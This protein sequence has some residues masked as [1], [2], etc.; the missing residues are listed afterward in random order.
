M[1]DAHSVSRTILPT[2]PPQWNR[3]QNNP[4]GSGVLFAATAIAAIVGISLL[5]PNRLLDRLW[6]LNK[7][8]AHCSAPSD[9]PPACFFWRSL[10]GT[11]AA[12]FGLLRR[13]RWA[14]WFAVVLFTI[15]GCGDVVSFLMTGD[16]LRSISG[17]VISAAFLWCLVGRRT[18]RY[19]L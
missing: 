6:E 19:F 7:P 3:D 2:G 16:A 18:R 5:F 9:G 15:D 4:G 8:G 12:A 17:A 13:K 14:W 11:C 1:Q 10:V